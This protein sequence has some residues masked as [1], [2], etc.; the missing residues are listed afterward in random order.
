MITPAL[1][2]VGIDFPAPW[3][4][5]IQFYNHAQEETPAEPSH[6]PRTAGAIH[7][8][9]RAPP[10]TRLD[11][12]RPGAV[13]ILKH[14][15][16]HSGHVVQC[17]YVGPLPGQVTTVEGDTDGSG[18]ST[19]DAAGRHTWEPDSGERGIVLGWFDWGISH[20]PRR[21][22]QQ[23]RDERAEDEPAN[24]E[25]DDV[26]GIENAVFGAAGHGSPRAAS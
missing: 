13:G 1:A 11:G 8:A 16:G 19:G 3:C 2:S 5:A 18:S 14:K 9:E 10:H 20:L 15:D 4:A 24:Q 6:C 23:P 21:H 7:M 26:D 17:E 12:P 22:S 25:R